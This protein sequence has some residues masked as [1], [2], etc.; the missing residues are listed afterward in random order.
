VNVY[1]R[2]RLVAL[3]IVVAALAV[4]AYLALGGSSSS[5]PQPTGPVVH[6]VQPAAQPKVPPQLAAVRP[7]GHL[8]LP[9]HTVGSGPF[10]TVSGKDIVRSEAPHG[11]GAVALT[12]DDGP[13]P[14]TEQ[15]VEKL[16]E[17]HATAT[18]FV[19]GGLVRAHPDVVRDERAAGMVVANHTYTHPAMTSLKVSSQRWQLNQTSRAIEAVVGTAP[20]FFRPPMWMWDAATVREAAQLGMITVLFS[21]DTQ[22]YTR[23]GVA[24]IVRT[25]VH[26]PAGSVIAFHDAGGDRTQTLRALPLIVHGLRARGL[27]IVTLDEL[28]AG[29]RAATA[30]SA[31]IG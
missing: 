31:P 6:E 1:L 23:P 16:V 5:R 13:G 7:R 17:L 10:V 26:A 21:V 2:R 29:R 25:A 9:T 8:A 30:G 11:A 20:R 27:R 24:A 12:F 22:D 19:L 18:F 3:A 4:P 28:Y 15:I 14:L